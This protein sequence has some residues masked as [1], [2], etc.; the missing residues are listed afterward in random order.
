[1]GVLFA[2]A[3]GYALP[4]VTFVHAAGCGVPVTVYLVRHAEKQPPPI[5]APPIKDPSLSEKGARRA[6][7]LKQMLASV[8]LD[9]VFATQFKRTQETVEPTAG[10]HGLKVEVVDADDVDGL[11]ARIRK[12]AG[13]YVLVA[14]HSNTVPDVAAALGASDPLALDDGDFGDLFIV[15]SSSGWV[16]RRRFDPP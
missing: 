1:L 11:V 7:A 5:G 16:E 8:K 3:L 4:M 10:A 15:N 9:A 2:D 13:G 6:A 12:H 14:G